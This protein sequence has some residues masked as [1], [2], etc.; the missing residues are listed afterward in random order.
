VCCTHATP[1]DYPQ[2]RIGGELDGFCGVRSGL[3]PEDIGTDR[4]RLSRDGLGLCW[5]TEYIDDVYQRVDLF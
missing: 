2:P 4:N 3:E 5:G 1:C